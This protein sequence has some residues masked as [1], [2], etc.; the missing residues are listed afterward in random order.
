MT[1]DPTEQAAPFIWATRGR[2]WGF[3]FLRTGGL[4]DP[5]PTYEAAFVEIADVPEG[6][7]R[8]GETVA[9][10]FPDP[11]Q[12]CDASG[13]VIPHDFVLFGRWAE[14]VDSVESG[15]QRIWDEVSDEFE[16]VWDRE[17]PPPSRP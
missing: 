3:R 10:R 8:T 15:R 4:S 9:V 5:L 2:D 6:W 16:V 11:Q 7:C 1:S 14:G 13:R 12:R 17:T